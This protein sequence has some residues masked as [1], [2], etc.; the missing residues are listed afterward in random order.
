M[1]KYPM[2]IFSN[3]TKVHIEYRMVARM[4]HV[5]EEFI[6]KCEQED[7]IK[8]CLM[9][10]GRKGLS[11]E[12]VRKLKL[13]RHYYED[14]GIDLEVVDFILRYR[15]QLKTLRR[16]LAEKD[17]LLREMGKVVPWAV[18]DSSDR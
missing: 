18:P 15:E 9:L 2:T 13:I 4:V 14:M 7:L 11:C 1:V 6:F 8:P 16:K 5:S 10:H 12:D 3:H 17:K